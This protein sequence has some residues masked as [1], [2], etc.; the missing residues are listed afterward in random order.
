MS[1]GEP[2]SIKQKPSCAAD[3]PILSPKCGKAAGC[4]YSNYLCAVLWGAERISIET[5]FSIEGDVPSLRLGQ[6]PAG[7]KF[8]P[9]VETF[10]PSCI[11]TH[12]HVAG[13]YDDCSAVI[14]KCAP[15]GADHGLREHDKHARRVR[16]CRSGGGSYTVFANT[17]QCVTMEVIIVWHVL[18][19]LTFPARSAWRSA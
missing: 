13:F 4:V 2:S 19:V 14:N 10:A 12:A 11:K 6:I 8:L 18:P 3:L 17:P 5:T 7:Q 9:M 16:R 1:G 15:R